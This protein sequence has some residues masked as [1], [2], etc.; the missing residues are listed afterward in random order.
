M[1]VSTKR[2]FW[3]EEAAR[4]VESVSTSGSDFEHEC[5]LLMPSGAIKDLQV[6]VHGLH[7]SF[8]NIELVGAVSD[9]TARKA[10]DE[11]I[12]SRKWSSVRYSTSH[13]N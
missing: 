1:E 12:Q 7:D 10:A 6:R 9:I 11:K 8:G 4:I 2:V 3:S 5:R 13:L